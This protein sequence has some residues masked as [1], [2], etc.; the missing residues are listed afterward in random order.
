M[1]VILS[2][3]IVVS[4][5]ALTIIFFIR[6]YKERSWKKFMKHIVFLFISSFVL[7]FYFDFFSVVVS[8]GNKNQYLLLLFTFTIL[9][10]FANY[11]FRH[12]SVDKSMRKE[13]DIGLFIAPVFISPIVSLPLFQILEQVNDTKSINLTIFVIAFQN[14]FLWKEYFDKKRKVATNEATNKE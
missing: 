7:N 3:T 13:W 11:A 2:W 10:M 4:I 9:G 8:K 12:F 6:D 1:S 5:A 14:G